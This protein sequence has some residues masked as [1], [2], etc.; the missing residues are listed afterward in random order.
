MLREEILAA[1]NNLPRVGLAHLPTP[2]EEC[3]RLSHFLNGPKILIKRDDCTGLAMGG[4]KT[5]ISEFTLGEAKAQGAD[6][7]IQ[8]ADSQSNHGRQL[9][10]AGAKLGLRVYLTHWKGEKGES[11]QGNL[12]LD[13]L[14]G[15]NVCFTDKAGAE[16]NME[17]KVELAEKLRSEGYKPYIMGPPKTPVLAAVAYLNCALEI[18]EQFKSMQQNPTYIYAASEGG[19][20]A[21]LILGNKLLNMGCKIIGVNPMP[22]DTDIREKIATIASEAAR[23]LGLPEV[24][25]PDDVYN[26]DEFVG[27]GYGKITE[28]GKE[29]ISLMAKYEGILLDPIYTG[30]A[31]SALISDIHEKKLTPQD[32]VVFMHTGGLPLIF[33][34]AEDLWQEN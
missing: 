18:S 7:I 3:P 2:L 34:Y 21:G 27:E 14:L 12:L 16:R 31:M 19:T 13:Y 1:I 28:A 23:L 25:S 6:T 26:T 22:N 4:N 10:A 11:K 29:A 9:A 20:Q 17:A 30:K 5:R 33:A 24:V 15:A 8:G 32:T